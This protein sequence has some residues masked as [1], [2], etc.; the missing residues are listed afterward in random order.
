MRYEKIL[1][2]KSAVKYKFESEAFG[3]YYYSD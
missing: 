1:A 3:K 2:L